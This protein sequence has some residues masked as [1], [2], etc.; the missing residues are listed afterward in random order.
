MPSWEDQASDSAELISQLGRDALPMFGQLSNEKW[1]RGGRCRVGIVLFTHKDDEAVGVVSKRLE[2]WVKGGG[3]SEFADKRGGDE[4]EMTREF[5]V[6]GVVDFD[7]RD[8]VNLS[9]QY[10]VA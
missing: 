3:A 10:K 5:D 2:H 9:G 4:Q 7:H 8:L 6:F 1:T